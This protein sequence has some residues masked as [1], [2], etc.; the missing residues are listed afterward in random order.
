MCLNGR[1][2][3]SHLRTGT[4]PG[5]LR[6]A[7]SAENRARG[8]AEQVQFLIAGTGCRQK[9][10]VPDEKS[11]KER[12]LS[13]EKDYVHFE[14]GD[15]PAR[16]IARRGSGAGAAFVGRHGSGQDGISPDTCKSSTPSRVLL[17]AERA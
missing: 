17:S 5:I 7:N 4:R 2:P 13:Q 11:S 15:F 1:E 6:H 14:E 9:Y 12:I 16:N 3:S 10:S 8:G